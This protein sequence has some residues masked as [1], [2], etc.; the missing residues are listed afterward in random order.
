[1]GLLVGLHVERKLGLGLVFGS[2]HVEKLPVIVEGLVLAPQLEDDF[3]GLPHPGADVHRFGVQSEHLEIAGCR[4]SADAE[5]EPPLGQVV[6]HGDAMRHHDRVMEVQE[7][8]AG[9]HHNLLGY[10]QGPGD[11]Q[12]WDRNVLPGED[13]VLPDPPP[14]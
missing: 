2:L 8:H 3:D 11:E 5:E 10:A 9:T 4:P 12:V 1:M 13:E 7:D 14:R 6:Q